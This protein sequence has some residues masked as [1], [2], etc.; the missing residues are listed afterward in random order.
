MHK[1]VVLYPK[2]ADP[3]QKEPSPSKVARLEACA[4]RV[5]R[6]PN[7]LPDRGLDGRG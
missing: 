5:P 4:D 7:Q 6:R 2:P 3:K 1:L